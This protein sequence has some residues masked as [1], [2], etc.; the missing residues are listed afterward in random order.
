MTRDEL[1]EIRADIWAEP[2]KDPSLFPDLLNKAVAELGL[3]ATN[4]D[5]NPAVTRSVQFW[6]E[7]VLRALHGRARS[8]VPFGEPGIDESPYWRANL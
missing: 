3:V 7:R 2:W 1:E 8:G 6:A 4:P 5:M